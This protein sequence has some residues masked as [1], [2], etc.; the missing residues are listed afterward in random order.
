MTNAA[1]SALAIVLAVATLSAAPASATLIGDTVVLSG[2][3]V[4]GSPRDLLVGAG[5]EIIFNDGGSIGTGADDYIEV[6]ISGSTIRLDLTAQLGG[7]GWN[8]AG[9]SNPFSFVFDSLNWV[10]DLTATIA[11]ISTTVFGSSLSNGG[12]SASLTGSNQIT[13]SWANNNFDCNAGNCG[14]IEI[15]IT[16][17]HS[18][19]PTPATLALFGLGLAGLG[20]SRRKQH[21]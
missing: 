4:P 13:V 18:E 7:F 6:D 11:S 21:S 12:A 17:N 19:V 9:L 16:P 5:S 15:E 20:W 10:D 14:G 3:G 8:P 1:L 2:A